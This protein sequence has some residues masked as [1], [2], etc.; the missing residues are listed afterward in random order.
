MEVRLFDFSTEARSQ[1]PGSLVLIHTSLPIFRLFVV[2][3]PGTDIP[4]HMS[5]AS[6]QIWAK[7]GKKI[8]DTVFL[9][10]FGAPGAGNW[11]ELEA[12]EPLRGCLNSK[13]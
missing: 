5:N 11:H 4:Y 9:S 12:D 8:C 13:P 2:L 7:V 1:P 3:R 6:S 10:F